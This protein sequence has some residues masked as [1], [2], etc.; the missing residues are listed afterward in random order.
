MFLPVRAAKLSHFRLDN[1]PFRDMIGQIIWATQPYLR[2]GG[3]YFQTV[4]FIS[5]HM[6]PYFSFWFD[7][8]GPSGLCSR[9]YVPL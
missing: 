4:S 1:H 6:A 8:I 9:E 2:I 5:F 7:C 3:E